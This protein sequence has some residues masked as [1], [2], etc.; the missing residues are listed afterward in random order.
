MGIYTIVESLYHDG[1]PVYQN[2]EGQ[3][4]YYW[5]PAL[6]W[7]MG[8][9]YM[10]GVASVMSDEDIGKCPEDYTE[11]KYSDNGW[12]DGQ[13]SITC[14]GIFVFEYDM[15]FFPKHS[16]I[17]VTGMFIYHSFTV[18]T[19]ALRQYQYQHLYTVSYRTHQ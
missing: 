2:D 14:L 3:Y 12:N 11:W 17:N 4:L 18:T 5:K 7:G 9:D 1:F 19:Y 6:E 13:M 8:S 16:K 15:L 10:S